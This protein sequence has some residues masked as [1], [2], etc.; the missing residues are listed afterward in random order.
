MN[1]E[2]DAAHAVA[3][4]KTRFAHIIHPGQPIPTVPASQE[5]TVTQPQQQPRIVDS[6]HAITA[7]IQANPLV[8]RLVEHRLGTLLTPAEADHFAALIAGLE[9]PRRVAQQQHDDVQQQQA[10]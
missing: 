1:I 5:N 7:E 8:A 10:G 6:L 4:A 2:A 3:A 9:Q